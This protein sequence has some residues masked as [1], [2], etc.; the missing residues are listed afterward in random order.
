MRINISVI[1]SLFI[2]LSVL[3]VACEDDNYISSDDAKLSFSTD[4][5]MFDTIFTTI[6]STTKSIRVVNTHNKPILISSIQ[7]GGLDESSYRLNIDGEMANEAREIEI[8][9]NDS[10]YIFV[11]LTIDPN[12]SNQPMVVADSIVFVTNSNIQDVKLMAWGQDFHPIN[13]EIIET[14][15][16]TND[17]PYLI[18]DYAVVDSSQVLTIQPG[19]Q[20]Y[21]HKD[22]VL[23]VI[24]NIQALGTPDMPIRFSGDRLEALYNDIPDQWG[25]IKL[26]P[27]ELPH[28]FD[29]V[30]II[31]ARTG[32]QVGEID[33]EGV[34]S[35]RLHNTKIEHMGYA[36]L[37]AVNANIEASNTVIS[38]CGFYCALLAGGSYDF[39]HC[40]IANYWGSYSNRQTPSVIMTNLLAFAQ[41]RDTI[42]F[43]GDLLKADWNNSIIWGNSKSEI[44]FG[45]NEGYQFNYQFTNSL[46]KIS[47]TL[48]NA[49]QENFKSSIINID[50]SFVDFSKYDYQLDTLSPAKDAGLLK[51]AEKIPYDLNNISRLSDELP[52]LGAYER[53]EKKAKESE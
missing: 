31:N 4:T 28:V 47:D 27:N 33:V 53:I 32:L 38:D 1:L 21:F 41:E 49:Q 51:Y 12:G 5:L 37:F 26:F 8:A 30:E 35:V 7:L 10:M 34:T 24:G 18:F 14:T 36:G 20:I 6:G 45:N 22:A 48:F 52:D 25:G 40:T 2:L 16:W 11:E 13:S 43:N 39:T 50:P 17:K 19:T 44:E 23:A 42:W 15:T 29:N 46:V 9:A 3:F